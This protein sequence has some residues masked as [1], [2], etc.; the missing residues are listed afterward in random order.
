MALTGKKTAKLKD[1]PVGTIFRVAAD[2][3]VWYKFNSRGT[4][5]PIPN[6]DGDGSDVQTWFGDTDIYVITH[7]TKLK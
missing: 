7:A 1:V 6:K 3:R 2:T 4:V 5:I